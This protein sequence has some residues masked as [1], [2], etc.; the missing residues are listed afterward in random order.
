MSKLQFS[1]LR[2][3]R[4]SDFLTSVQVGQKWDFDFQPTWSEVCF[5]FPTSCR[6]VGFRNSVQ[7]GQNYFFEIFSWNASKN[8][9]L[10]GYHWER[11]F[12]RSL[13]KTPIPSA[14]TWRNILKSRRR[15]THKKFSFGGY[16]LRRTMDKKRFS[17]ATT[18][19][20]ILM[21]R[22]RIWKFLLEVYEDCFPKPVDKSLLNVL[23]SR[24]I[25][26]WSRW[27]LLF[28]IPNTVRDIQKLD[29]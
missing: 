23:T 26:F 13:T 8:A 20:E 28:E 24:G 27:K 21:Y 29:G 7:L 3:L 5:L 1:L 16:H 10:V 15:S 9:V 17:P 4:R 18:W 11:F 6:E 22:V 2:K 19:K 12:L 25:F 14:T